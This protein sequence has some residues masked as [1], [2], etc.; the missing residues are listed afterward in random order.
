MNSYPYLVS[1]VEIIFHVAR[2]SLFKGISGS[3]IGE[4]IHCR[5]PRSSDLESMLEF[6]PHSAYENRRISF[7][8]V[9]RRNFLTAM[10]IQCSPSSYIIRPRHDTYFTLG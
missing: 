2:R 7:S 6:W 3:I 8:K 10:L 4:C 5:F 1:C 9:K